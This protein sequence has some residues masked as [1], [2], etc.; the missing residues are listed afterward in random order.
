MPFVAGRVQAGSLTA[1]KSRL[2]FC[3]GEKTGLRILVVEDNRTLAAGLVAV[4][5]GDGFAVDL[6]HDGASATAAVAA[7]AFDLVV[8]D[9]SLPEVDGLHVLRQIRATGK[10]TAVL[11]LTARSALDERVRGLDLG[12]DDYMTKPFEVPEFEARVRVLLRRQS[13]TRSST[14]HFQSLSLDTATRTLSANG[15]LLEVPARELSLIETLM[16]RAGKVVSK[17]AIIESLASFEDDLSENAVEQ[18]ISRLRKRLAPHGVTIRTARG[19]GYYLDKA[20]D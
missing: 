4:L 18:Y 12:A 19:L 14:A 9:L 11:I 7:E 17:Q 15:E 13:G 3:Y 16:R 6:V 1:R 2:T 5:R 10:P 8:L 20:Q